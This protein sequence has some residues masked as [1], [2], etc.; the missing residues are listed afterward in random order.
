MSAPENSGGGGLAPDLCGFELTFRMDE[1]SI[2]AIMLHSLQVNSIANTYTFIVE[3]EK[4][5]SLE[6]LKK[7]TSF[8]SKEIS[9]IDIYVIG[10]YQKTYL[11]SKL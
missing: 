4:L 9:N 8:D 6:K 3:A 2:V 11:F 1:F 10:V 7:E 5:S